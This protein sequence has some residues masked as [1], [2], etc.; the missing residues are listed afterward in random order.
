MEPDMAQTSFSDFIDRERQRIDAAREQVQATIRDLQ[1][2]LDALDREYGAIDAYL[3]AREGKPAGKRQSRGRRGS[4]REALI[5]LLRQHPTGLSRGE[6]LTRMDLKG[7]R[8]GEMS[9]SNALTALTKG[10]HADRREG[11]YYPTA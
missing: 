2:K 8:S 10:N 11:K 4:K 5:Q 3:A 9:V 7:D 1:G 6:I